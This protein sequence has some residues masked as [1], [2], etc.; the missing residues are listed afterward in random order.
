MQGVATMS[1]I[2]L[3][4]IM[5][6]VIIPIVI[7]PSIINHFLSPCCSGLMTVRWNDQLIKWLFDKMTDFN[8]F[9]GWRRN[10]PHDG[11]QDNDT[12]NKNNMF[13][14][15]LFF[16]VIFQNFIILN[17]IMQGVAMMSVIITSVLC[18]V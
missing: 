1:V 15:P 17:V 4:V 3:S 12:Q 7:L 8:F 14:V 2:I 16:S 6:N 13:W 10:K 9:L 11:N 5:L 18:W